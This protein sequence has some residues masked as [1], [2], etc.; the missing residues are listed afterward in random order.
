MPGNHTIN[1]RSIYRSASLLFCSGPAAAYDE[2]SEENQT[3]SKHF[4]PCQY[5]HS[6]DYAD[7]S[8]NYRLYVAV[9]AHQC[10]AYPFLAYRNKEVAYECSEYDKVAQFPELYGRYS[11]PGQAD[12]FPERHRHCHQGGEQEY[13]LHECHHRI[14]GYY[15]LEYAKIKGE[16]QTVQK[17]QQNASDAAF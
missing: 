12:D 6:D 14:S 5:I 1:K 11:C 13:P 3:R 7:H 8:G 10:R 2:Y 16:A 4:L 9:H 15:R 17:H